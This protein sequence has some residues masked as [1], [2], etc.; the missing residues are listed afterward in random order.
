MII[1]IAKHATTPTITPTTVVDL[2]KNTD[3]QGS[4]LP[5]FRVLDDA[6]NLHFYQNAG[7][8]L[9]GSFKGYIQWGR[10]RCH[11]KSMLAIALQGSACHFKTKIQLFCCHIFTEHLLF[12]K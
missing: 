11:F 12:N 9:A 3:S 10:G 5:R 6:R 7:I 2:A 8:F 1:I 4:C